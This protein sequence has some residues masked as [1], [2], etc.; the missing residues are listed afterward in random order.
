M[1][2]KVKVVSMECLLISGGPPCFP[3]MMMM[4]MMNDVDVDVDDDDDLA[5]AFIGPQT[6]R[7]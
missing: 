6:P 3:Q 7:K 1:M 5:I 2:I 4:M